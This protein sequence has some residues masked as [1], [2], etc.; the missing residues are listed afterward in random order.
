M[1]GIIV[2]KLCPEMRLEVDLGVNWACPSAEP[3]L[4]VLQ[5][6]RRRG[7]PVCPSTW[8]TYAGSRGSKINSTSLNIKPWNLHEFL[9]YFLLES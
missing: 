2:Q 9:R 7:A 8:Q 6:E 4:R 1:N 3:F 5:D